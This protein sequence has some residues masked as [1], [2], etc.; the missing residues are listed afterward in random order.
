MVSYTL[1]NIYGIKA[2]LS[3]KTRNEK[4]KRKKNWGEKDGRKGE[5]KERLEERN[6]ASKRKHARKNRRNTGNN[7]ASAFIFLINK[8]KFTCT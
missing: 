1:V 6:L 7:E 4:K 8:G 5:N 3:E 2:V